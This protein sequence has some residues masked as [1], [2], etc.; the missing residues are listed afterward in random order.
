M[1][2]QLS[3][4]KWMPGWDLQEWFEWYTRQNPES[5][6]PGGVPTLA[7]FAREGASN[8]REGAGNACEW[9]S[10]IRREEIGS[11]GHSDSQLEP[12]AKRYKYVENDFDP[13][14]DVESTLK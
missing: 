7:E 11:P 5:A 2:S 3:L 4:Q 12:H 6:I 10:D 8:A 14:K 9:A 13:S 1:Q